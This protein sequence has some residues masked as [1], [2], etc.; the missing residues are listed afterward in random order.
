MLDRFD[1]FVCR[2]KV[3]ARLHEFR[4]WLHSVRHVF[5]SKCATKAN[6]N[7]KVAQLE[8]KRDQAGFE[9]RD[10][11]ASAAHDELTAIK[12]QLCGFPEAGKK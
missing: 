1:L 10:E 9:G 4:K 7:A 12:M 5:L 3:E 2:L 8:R 11:D 6:V